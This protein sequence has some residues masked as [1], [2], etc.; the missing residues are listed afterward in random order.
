MWRLSAA[1]GDVVLKQIEQASRPGVG[2]GP[3]RTP[4][5]RQASRRRVVVIRSREQTVALINPTYFYFADTHGERIDY[6]TQQKGIRDEA[7]AG[8]LRRHHHRAL[9]RRRRLGRRPRR[10]L[11][12]QGRYME[13]MTLQNYRNVP[14]G[15]NAQACLAVAKELNYPVIDIWTKM[16]QF[17]D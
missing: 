2:G 12:P 7:A 11:R 3:C 4:P 16:Q 13:K 1:A 5:V 15:T 8:A 17:P 14:A 9:L 10:P 6:N